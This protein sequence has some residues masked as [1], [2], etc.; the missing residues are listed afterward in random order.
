MVEDRGVDVLVTGLARETVI[1]DED[2]NRSERPLDIVDQLFW[3]IRICHVGA[4]RPRCPAAGNDLGRERLSRL[5]VAAVG[6]GESCDIASEPPAD[7]ATD[8]AARSRDERDAPGQI[9]SVGHRAEFTRISRL[10]CSKPLSW[11]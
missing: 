4:E 11:D 7:R 5:S 8:T 3:S 1:G 9:E 6:D 10:P 2:V